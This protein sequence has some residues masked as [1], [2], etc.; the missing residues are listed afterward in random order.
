MGCLNRSF[1]KLLSSL[2]SHVQF[3][4]GADMKGNVRAFCFLIFV[5]LA[6]SCVL[7]AQT[8]KAGK[9]PQIPA[10]DQLDSLQGSP[11]IMT[12]TRQ[13]AQFWEI[14]NDLARALGKKDQA[15]LGKMLSED[16]KVWMPNQ[17][18]SAVAGEDWIKSGQENPTPTLVRQM[19][20]QEYPDIMLV[21][22]LGQ[23]KPPVRGKG[24][25][26]QYFVV[27]VWARDGDAW[28]LTDRFMSRIVPIPLSKRPSGKE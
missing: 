22:F 3:I 2:K 24:I 6:A 14:E 23:G 19:S 11:K 8:R 16:F 17:T 9:P 25:A 15:A 7:A 28:Q 4:T 18:G 10:P 1:L 27:D 21:K 20:A 5:V 26:N 12:T 13:V